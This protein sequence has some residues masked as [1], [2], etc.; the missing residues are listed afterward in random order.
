MEN[1][2][3]MLEKSLNIDIKFGQLALTQMQNFVFYF[4]LLFLSKSCISGA[5]HFKEFYITSQ[6][7]INI[8]FV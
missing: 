4:I 7:C 8:M 2:F 5:I 3:T 6:K 1:T